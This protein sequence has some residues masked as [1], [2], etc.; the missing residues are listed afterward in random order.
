M[1]KQSD[2]F[3]AAFRNTDRTLSIKMTINDDEKPFTSEDIVSVQYDSAA[4]TGDTFGIGS[5][6]ENSI[7]VVFSELQENIKQNDILKP[8]IGIQL[9]DGTFEYSP[10][11]VFIVSDQIEQDRNNEQTTVTA[12]DKMAYLEGTYTPS[13]NTPGSVRSWVLEIANMAGVVINEENIGRL[14]TEISI[15]PIFKQTYRTALGMLAQFVGGYVVFNRAGELEIRGLSDTVYPVSPDNYEFQGLTK[16]ETPYSL[17]GI[18][19]EVTKTSTDSDGNSSDSTV[20]LHTG[21]ETGSQVALNNPS[22]TQS[23]LD[24]ILFKLRGLNFYPYTLNWFGNPAVEAGD[25]LEI[26]DTKGNKFKVPNN[27]Y[28]LTFD[29]SVSAVSSTSETV[30]NSSSYSYQGSLNQVLHD[31][32]GRISAG[33]GNFVY[34]G[35]DEPAYP[36]E[37]DIWYKDVNGKTQM[38]IYENGEWVLKADDLT[39]SDLQKQIDDTVNDVKNAQDAANDVNDKVDQAVT[40]WNKSKDEINDSILA[41]QKEADDKIAAADKA[42][43]DANTSITDVNKKISDAN[44]SITD[45]NKK[46]SDANT[47]IT[48]AN[49]KALSAYSDAQDALNKLI[50]VNSRVDNLSS[51]TQAKFDTLNN[52]YQLTLNKIDNLQIGGQNYVRN[53]NLAD[54]TGKYWRDWN[55]ATGATRTINA[56]GDDWP[57]NTPGLMRLDNPNGGQ[58]G[59]AQDGIKVDDNAYYVISALVGATTTT[60]VAL[61]HGDGNADPWEAK[62]FT[63]PSGKTRITFTFKTGSAVKTTNA[64]VGFGNNGKGTIWIS[65]IKLER[66]NKAT[67]WTPAPEDMATQTQITTITGLIDSKVSQ[68]QYDSDRLQTA[69]Q[70]ADK[71][72]NNDFNSFKS[73]TA[74]SIEQTVEDIS[75]SGQRNLVYNS[76][77]ENNAD[78]W[79]TTNVYITNA[80]GS[81]YQGSLGLAVNQKG[82]GWLQFGASKPYKLPNP[83]VDPANV[84]SASAM[85]K[86]YDGTSADASIGITLAFLNSSGTR[87]TGWKDAL[88]K[89]DASIF[90]KWVLVKAENVP[91]PAGAESVVIQYQAY[92]GTVA[93]NYVHG[94]ITHPM[95]TFG[96]KVG[97]Y[98]PDIVEK[99]TITQLSNLIDSKVSDAT[100]QSDK[101][102][103]SNLISS[104]VSSTDFNSYKTQTD[105]LIS[106]KV[107]ST[108]FNSY[109]TQTDGLISSKVSSS[110]FNSYKTQTDKS[111]SMKVSQSDFDNLQ[112]G[113]I[114]L[115]QNSNFADLTGK[116]WRNWG[117]MTGATRE[118]I[119]AGADW[120]T[121]TGGTMQLVSP[122]AGQWGYAQDG[123]K[124]AKGGTYTLSA[125]VTGAQGTKLALQHG[126]GKIDPWVEQEIIKPTAGMDTISYTFKVSNTAETTNIYVGFGTNGKGKVWISRIKLEEGNHASPWTAA[127]DDLASATDYANLEIEV[128]GIQGTV[129]NKADKSQVTQLADQI[130]SV[131]SDVDS[132]TSQ[133]AQMADDI[134]L[135]V[136]EGDVVN[137][138]NVDGSGVLIDG[139]KVHITGQTTIDN[140]V[141]GN[142]AIGDLSADKITTG[143]INAS[144]VNLINLNASSISTGTLTGSNLS[145]NLNTGSVKFQ[146][147]KIYSADEAVDI[148]IDKKYISV[149]DTDNR[150]LLKGGELQFVEPLW[151]FDPSTEPYLKIYNKTFQGGIIAGRDVVTIGVMGYVDGGMSSVG[152]QSVKGLFVTSA[153]NGTPAA[154]LGG[155]EAG[156]EISGGTGV[157]RDMIK[158][159]PHIDVGISSSSGGTFGSNNI[160]LHGEHIYIDGS[161][162]TTY[163][164]YIT[165]TSQS[166]NMYVDANGT[167]TRSSS[168]S[169][170]KL[171]INEF[172]DEE[173]A[174]AL[175][176]ISAKSWFDKR[177]TEEIAKELTDGTK[178]ES[179][180]PRLMPHLGFV[181]EDLANAGLE[182][183]VDRGKDNQLE[184]INYDRISALEHLN[185]QELFK[186]VLE[187]ERE[188]Y[189][190]RRDLN[191]S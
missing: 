140:G 150:I 66:G 83:T 123:I 137:Q 97:A 67:D 95:L 70:I 56:A 86:V 143:T 43:S 80:P 35:T 99:S 90:N 153:E 122:N 104:K 60:T 170:Y 110:D 18:S 15:A 169:K 188:V 113:G 75:N 158:S 77:Y 144:N 145:L 37:N 136:K 155:G 131:V 129:A 34:T 44:A 191:E 22:M 62:E 9:P 45:V 147:G 126:D 89:S 32:N 71:V 14:P 82:S 47:A 87:I 128:N 3:N 189:E 133:I 164:T 19:C 101:L 120:P 174:H 58:W 31:M 61:Q 132:N 162:T 165:P 130:T 154:L 28:V 112:T 93:T 177:E 96:P 108:D 54:L 109:K 30:T 118:I 13:I 24:D 23:L 26:E 81:M 190:L 16:S 92:R 160:R 17:S 76:E 55:G 12:V 146:K 180:T 139:E 121:N 141:I 52:G 57:A 42:I 29:G 2:A 100:Y 27:S 176:A 85:V 148:D 94:V 102:Q 64:Y 36:K 163:S 182:M 105:G 106:S 172:K 48:N 186:R 21:K 175:L 156:I 88:V 166:A 63:I 124:V 41:N 39:G 72:S 5:T 51:D 157:S 125:V 171:N 78:G 168:A 7:K 107:S 185:V 114:N 111:I 115:L 149:A 4:Y 178:P 84:Y 151:V 65:Q 138:I 179:A 181:A 8:Q 142:A 20:S 1:L 33:G 69:Q 98:N 91:V 134:N 127:L 159:S 167:L 187:L 119:K 152:L 135:R 46:I 10:L 49:N 11:G 117:V 25:F 6:Y 73:Q 59:Y 79:T 183:L 53:G 173:Q 38:Y 74:N 103:M 50:L 116:Y 161:S 40:D 184:G 68:G